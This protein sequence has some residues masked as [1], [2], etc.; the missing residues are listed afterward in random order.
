MIQ[1]IKIINKMELEIANNFAEKWINSWNSHN[2]IS[3]YSELE[4]LHKFIVITNNARY[5]NND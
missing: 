5:S 1:D 4:M 3:N 2:I